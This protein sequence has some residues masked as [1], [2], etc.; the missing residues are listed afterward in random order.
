M[1]SVADFQSIYAYNWQVLR[2]YAAALSKLPETE[3]TKNREATHESLKNIFHHILSVHD[4]WLNV[5]VQR[6]SADPVVREMD[7]DE[8]RSMDVLRD[9]MEKIIKKEEGFFV[10]LSDRDLGRP[11]QP[12][13][14]TR[15][16]ALRD[17]LLQVTFEQAHHLGE[18][19]A[20]FWQMDVEP[21]EMTWIDV[22]LAMKGDPGPS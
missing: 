10:T 20:L 22:G 2:D 1:M 9:Y 11:V 16:H 4:G 18:L 14:K 6:A 7:F 17:A 15:P 3:L 19:I 5:T 12:E 13:W 21:P 8:V